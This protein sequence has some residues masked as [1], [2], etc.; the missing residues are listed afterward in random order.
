MNKAKYYFL[1]LASLVGI[2]LHAQHKIR[3]L[4]TDSIGNPLI[5]AG[6]HIKGT[7]HGT[8]TD[9]NGAFVL[10]VP[11]ENTTLIFSYVGFISQERHINSK[12]DSLLIALLPNRYQIKEHV[13]PAIPLGWKV[14]SIG[15]P[16]TKEMMERSTPPH[17]TADSSI[18]KR[19]KKK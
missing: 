15:Y 19:T 10:S 16:V 13:G 9:D 14:K 11:N 6:I 8:A 4:M 2:Q 17:Q 3:G 5:G 18:Y 12:T 1:L 7:Q